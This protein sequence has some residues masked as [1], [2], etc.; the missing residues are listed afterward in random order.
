MEDRDRGEPERQ[1][2]EAENRKTREK[3]VPE[4]MDSS[5]LERVRFEYSG[6]APSPKYL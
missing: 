5:E 3:K 4:T 1:R 6:A 2:L